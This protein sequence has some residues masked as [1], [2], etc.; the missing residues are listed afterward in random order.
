MQKL[1]RSI[2]KQRNIKSHE[3]A[4]MLKHSQHNQIVNVDVEISI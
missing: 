2:M 1:A 4:N 3:H